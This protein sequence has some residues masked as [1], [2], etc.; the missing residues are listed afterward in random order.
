MAISCRCIALLCHAPCVSLAVFKFHILSGHLRP[1][2]S[3]VILE[4]AQ[5]AVFCH[6]P[7]LSGHPPQGTIHRETFACLEYL[8]YLQA[9]R[10]KREEERIR[11][12]YQLEKKQVCNHSRAAPP[13]SYTA[14]HH[15]QLLVDYFTDLLQDSS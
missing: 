3:F 4:W 7:S 11:A 8:K 10:E 12:T 14:P 13:C 15:L 6:F 5:T 1:G 9:E 2:T